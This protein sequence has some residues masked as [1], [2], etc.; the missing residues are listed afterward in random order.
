MVSNESTIFYLSH[1]D[2]EID[3]SKTEAKPLEFIQL[4]LLGNTY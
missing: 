3:L 4:K 1:G 2:G